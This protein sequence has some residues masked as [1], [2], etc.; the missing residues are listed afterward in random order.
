MY[1]LFV[2]TVKL[3][4]LINKQKINISYDYFRMY[5]NQFEH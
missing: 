1:K 2:S 5:Q 4:V 3:F